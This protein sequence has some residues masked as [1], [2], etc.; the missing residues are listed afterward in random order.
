MYLLTTF[1]RQGNVVKNEK[2]SSDMIAVLR[3]QT[4]LDGAEIV[5]MVV[6]ADA[7]KGKR[8]PA[9]TD[10]AWYALTSY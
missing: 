2:Y 10:T 7:R 8:V 5:K 3:E 4:T 1:D 6:A 9:S